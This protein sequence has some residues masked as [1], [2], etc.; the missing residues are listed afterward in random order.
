[1]DFRIL[2]AELRWGDALSKEDRMLARSLTFGQLL[3]SSYLLPKLHLLHFHATLLALLA[4][5]LYALMQQR[6]AVVLHRCPSPAASCLVHAAQRAACS[7]G[8]GRGADKDIMGVDMMKGRASC[9]GR[10]IQV[11]RG[12]VTGL[13]CRLGQF[14]SVG[15]QCMSELAWNYNHL[16]LKVPVRGKS[17]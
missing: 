8:E 3:R 16:W 7:D 10:G 5:L 11:G 14:I 15:C 13:S 17:C 6:F 2:L 9:E 4:P 12:R 1:M